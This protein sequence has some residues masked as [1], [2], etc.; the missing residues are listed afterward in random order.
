MAYELI[1]KGEHN[2]TTQ[3]TVAVVNGRIDIMLYYPTSDEQEN[4]S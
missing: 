2:D 4:C 1:F 3:L